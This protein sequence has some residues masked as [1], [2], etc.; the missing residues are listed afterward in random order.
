MGWLRAGN[1]RHTK[2]DWRSLPFNHPEHLATRI[3]RGA[4]EHTYPVWLRVLAL[5]CLLLVAGMSSVQA[6]H[7]HGQW[8]PQH[9]QLAGPAAD[10]SQAPGGEDHCPLCVAMHWALPVATHV[11]P[12]RTLL[13]ECKLVQRVDRAPE[14]VWHFAMFSRPPPI[15]TL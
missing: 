13:V 4:M 8:L 10:G 14:A 2:R 11:V 3:K 6:V 7:V 12:A 1:L 5:A 9:G 15:E